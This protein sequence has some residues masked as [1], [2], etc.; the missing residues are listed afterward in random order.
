MKN[1][2]CIFCGKEFIGRSDKKR[3]YCS[4]QC[5]W[6]AGKGQFLKG[7]IPWNYKKPNNKIRNHNHYNWKGGI[8]KRRSNRVEWRILRQKV[9]ERDCYICQI[10]KCKIEKKAQVHHKLDWNKYPQ[11]RWDINNLITLCIVCHARLHTTERNYE[12]QQ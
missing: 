7:L 3:K 9:L 12:C 8:S 2:V 4:N 5:K 6:E 10:C 11:Y 1:F